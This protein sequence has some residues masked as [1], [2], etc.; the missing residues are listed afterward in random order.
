MTNHATSYQELN[1]SLDVQNSPQPSAAV[2]A[3]MARDTLG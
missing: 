2:M 1:K 3:A